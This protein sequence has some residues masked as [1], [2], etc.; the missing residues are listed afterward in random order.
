MDG[1]FTAAYRYGELAPQRSRQGAL[2]LARRMKR[3]SSVRFPS[4]ALYRPIFANAQNRPSFLDA[5]AVPAF[6]SLPPSRCSENEVSHATIAFRLYCTEEA[7]LTNSEP[8]YNPEFS[9][10]YL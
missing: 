4:E 7:M 8:Q 10:R 5:C 1:G 6:A 9:P 2:C 3:Q